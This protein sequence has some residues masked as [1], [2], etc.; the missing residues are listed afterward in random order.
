MR[1][2]VATE[3]Q[4]RMWE[5]SAREPALWFHRFD[6]YYRPLGPERNL[7]RAYKA[8]YQAEKG[9][10]SRSV[11]A[12]TSWRE[13]ADL[14]RWA[15]RAE[16][17]DVG[18]RLARLK[19]EDEARRK[20]REQRIA[21]LQGVLLRASTAVM[22]LNPDEAK[23]GDVIA[24]ARLAVQELRHEYGEDVTTVRV[25][26]AGIMPDW[27]TA[28]TEMEPEQLD[29]IIANLLVGEGNG[30]QERIGTRS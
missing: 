26:A 5:R 14:W 8:W 20:S 22:N 7:L 16:A 6:A 21:I 4:A 28:V 9:R 11:S 29:W 10:V 1:P 17:W 3:D 15:E 2:T 24:A 25:E 27:A 23:W 13:A 30:N 12:P 18:Q 19:E